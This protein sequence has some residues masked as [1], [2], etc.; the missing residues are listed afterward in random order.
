MEYLLQHHYMTDDKTALN[1]VSTT[2]DAMENGGIYDQVGGGFARYSV[3]QIWKV[4][5]FEKMLYDNGQLVSLYAEAYTATGNPLYK[6]VVVETL[7][8]IE[9]ELTDKTGAFYSALDADSEGEEGKFYVWKKE[10]LQQILDTDFDVFA[11]YYSINNK[12]LWEHG[13]YILLRDKSI[14]SVAKKNKSNVEEVE[15]IIKNARKK[16][17]KERDKR[18]RPGLDDKSLTSW[19]ALMLSGYVD[20]Y[21]A[22][23]DQSY[24]DIAIK[25]ARFITETQRRSDGGLNHSYKAGRSTINGYLEDYS[26]TIEA[27]V[28]LYEATFDQHWIDEA[29]KLADYAI[30]HFHDEEKGLFYFTSDMDQ[31]LIAR[32]KEISDNVIPAS[33]SSMAK[34]LFYLGHYFDQ[35]AY[36]EISETMLNNVAGSIEKYPSGYSNWMQ[37]LLHHTHPFYEIAISG[38]DA[39][40]KRNEFQTHY[41]PNKL[42]IG[43]VMAS[44][45]PLLKFKDVEGETMIYVCLD[46]MCKL[47]VKE[48]ADAVRLME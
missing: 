8:F 26:F 36:L 9:R 14:E 4:P 41:F 27:L 20:A 5:H 7:E 42:L 3:D 18:I 38:K 29:H 24:L 21:F 45:L 33:N 30:A 23:Q 31:A 43:S 32:K 37:L 13:N 11:D 6:Q 35:S 1:A 12:G 40:Q 2:L 19:N 34:G 44:E 39:N 17:M 48:V 47:P 15:S 25:N 28:K 46:K 16:L 10:E 22:F